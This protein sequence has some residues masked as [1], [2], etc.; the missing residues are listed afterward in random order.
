[1]IVKLYNFRYIIR[2]LDF[3]RDR[4]GRYEMNGHKIG[5]AGSGTY[6]AWLE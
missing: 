2:Y 6:L 5:H 3:P 4:S 1:M